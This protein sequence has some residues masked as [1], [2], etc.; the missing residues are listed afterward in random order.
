MKLIKIILF[1]LFIFL[2]V[3]LLFVKDFQVLDYPRYINE[4]PQPLSD[5]DGKAYKVSQTFRTPGPLT[6]IDIMLGNYKVKPGGGMLQLGIFEGDRCLFLKR[7]PADEVEDNQFYT[8][9]IAAGKIAAGD[10][11]LQLKYLPGDR[12]ER[13]AVWTGLEGKYPYGDFF[14][15]GKRVEGDMTFRV[16]YLSTLWSQGGRLLE[17]VPGR[18]GG[19]IWLVLGFV[20]LLLALNFLF[21]YFINRLLTR[22]GAC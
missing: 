13:L 17:G 6:R 16:Y 3:Y 2:Q 14:V 4:F 21:Y 10:Y 8:F 1:A 15:D 7:Y 11:A 18:W 12:V 9:G 19:R 5:E 20:L 22:R